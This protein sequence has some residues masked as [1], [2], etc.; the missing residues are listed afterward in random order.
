[1]GK[2]LRSEELLSFVRDRCTDS[3]MREI[4]L[5]EGCEPLCDAVMAELLARGWP[6]DDL[7]Y[8]RQA[9]GVFCRRRN[10]ILFPPE[11]GGI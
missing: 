3:E 8:L 4:F 5:L 6:K 1:M 7:D 2:D 11:V 10:W 9:G